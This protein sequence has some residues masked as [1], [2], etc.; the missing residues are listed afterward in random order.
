MNIG[1]L[2]GKGDHGLLF[3]RGIGYNHVSW[4]ETTA[5]ESGQVDDDF[6]GDF[7]MF[8]LNLT[9]WDTAFFTADAEFTTV[10]TPDNP[11]VVAIKDYSGRE[12]RFM[13]Y[14]TLTADELLG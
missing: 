8:A 3:T 13:V 14:K 4:Y 11:N 7:D 5:Q 10:S 1:E 6:P 9:D 2:L 12:H